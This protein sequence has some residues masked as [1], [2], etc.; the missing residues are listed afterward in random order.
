MRHSLACIARS[1]SRALFLPHDQHTQPPRL[2]SFRPIN[3][4][5]KLIGC[6]RLRAMHQPIEQGL[7]VCRWG[8]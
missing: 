8:H 2:I 1:A 4:R 3:E 7:L 5:R 6:E